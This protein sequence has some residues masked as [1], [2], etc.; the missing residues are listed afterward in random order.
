MTHHCPSTRVN[1]PCTVA[2]VSP[3]TARTRAAAATAVIGRS[4]S[5]T[6]TQCLPPGFSDTLPGRRNK[7]PG[8][9]TSTRSADNPHRV[10]RPPRKSVIA[11]APADV[12]HDSATC[13]ESGLP[14]VH[15]TYLNHRDA[16]QHEFDRVRTATVELP[17][18]IDTT[19][20]AAQLAATTP[21]SDGPEPA[22]RPGLSTGPTAHQAAQ[23]AAD[24]PAPARLAVQ[25]R[26][27]AA[28]PNLSGQRQGL[29]ASTLPTLTTAHRSASER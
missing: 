18:W 8:G 24:F 12:A 26:T 23:R 14:D 7:W 1:S 4:S 3:S 11:C 29:I 13:T 16:V 10:R 22:S 21:G 9:C 2:G 15:T 5:S 27:G 28:D 19:A 6:G 20:I 17:E 25:S